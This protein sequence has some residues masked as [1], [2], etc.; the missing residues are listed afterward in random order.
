MAAAF[1]GKQVWITGAG[2]GIGRAAAL[3]FAAEGAHVALIGRRRAMLDEVA[4]AIAAAGGHAE[5]APLDVSRRADVDAAAGRLLATHR[6]V[7][8]LVN[9]AG[10]NVANRRLD[11]VRPED[12]D[13]VLAVN[14]TGA[15]NMAMAVMAPMRAQGSGLIINVALDGREARERGCRDRLFRVQVRDP[16]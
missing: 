11:E 5:V 15:F 4:G 3:M 13:E 6:R 14:L 9:N 8:I 10:I 2:T 1:E 12:W 16:G 7:D